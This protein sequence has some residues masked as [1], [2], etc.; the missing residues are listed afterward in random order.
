ME[1]PDS[2]EQRKKHFRRI[3]R[4]KWL[5]RFTPRKARL[6]RYPLI[7]RFADVAR[8]RSYLWSFRSEDARPALYAGS[9]LALLPVMGVQIPVAFLLALLM[10]KNVM[11]LAGLQ[12]ITNPFTAAFIYYGTYQLGHWV[13]KASGFGAS[14]EVIPA[15]GGTTILTGDGSVLAPPEA[16]AWSEH[17]GTTFNALVIG[18]VLLGLLLGVVLD[19]VWRIVAARVER[20]RVRREQQRSGST[21]GAAAAE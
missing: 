21:T 15:S 6:H 8:K 16:L 1:N 2:S 20:R 9:I 3:R 17:L 4:T 18:G 14:T 12:M 7:G 11:I 19:I 13:T 5:L 10:R